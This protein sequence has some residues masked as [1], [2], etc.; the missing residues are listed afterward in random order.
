MEWQA[1]DRRDSSGLGMQRRSGD[2]N[3]SRAQSANHVHL[4]EILGVT[5]VCFDAS[6]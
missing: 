1:G 6:I 3:S 4:Q 2:Q 5:E